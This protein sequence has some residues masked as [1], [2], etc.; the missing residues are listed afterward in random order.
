MPFHVLVAF[1][2][3]ALF[4]LKPFVTA[5]TLGS[6]AAGGVFTPF[7]STG[8][9]LG[10]FLGA[11]W[12]H[13]WPGTPVGAFALVGAAVA[14]RRGREPGQRRAGLQVHRL[15]QLGQRLSRRGNR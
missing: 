4:A 5:L 8:A 13:V 7:L 6:G 2:G 1:T 9:A 3:I 14:R 10:A 11:L 15:A 12:I